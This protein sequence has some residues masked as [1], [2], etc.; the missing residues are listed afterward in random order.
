MKPTP[1]MIEAARKAYVTELPETALYPS[2]FAMRAALTAAL[3]LIPVQPQQVE[4]YQTLHKPFPQKSR[5]HEPVNSP[6][7]IRELAA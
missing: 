7:Q 2:E 5:E 3:A 4:A 6:C 1:E